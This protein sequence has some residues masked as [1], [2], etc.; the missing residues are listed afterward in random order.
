[1]SKKLQK[2]ADGLF[3]EYPEQDRVF[4]T[5]DEQAFFS[6]NAADAHQIEQ[7]FENEVQV[8]FREGIAPTDTQDLQ[9]AYEQ[10]VEAAEAKDTLLN[11]IEN[12][13]DLEIPVPQVERDTHEVVTKVIQLRE[14]YE[15]VAL[16]NDT[17]KKEL[18]E[19]K[20]VPKD[21]EA[22]TDSKKA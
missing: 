3:K 20:T 16:E 19:L 17:L 7:G 10:A 12:A 13:A 11:Q 2:R 8:F 18:E 22:K 5:Q 1:M 14:K 4:F 21:G 15:Q 9:E 6:K